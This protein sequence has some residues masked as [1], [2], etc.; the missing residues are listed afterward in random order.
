MPLRKSRAELDAELTREWRQLAG[1][2]ALLNQGIS[3]RLGINGT[4]LQCLS[5]L[6][7][8]GPIAAGQLAERTGL[9]TGAVTGVIDRLEKAGLVRRERDSVDRRKVIVQPLSDEELRTRAPELDAV[10]RSILA[11]AESEATYTDEQLDLIVRF[12]RRSHP[13]IQNQI[14]ALRRGTD[15]ATDPSAP[16]AGTTT[17]RLIFSAGVAHVTIDGEA[18]SD[19]LYRAHF[20]GPVPEIRVQDGTVAVRYRRF[21][22]FEGRPRG[23]RFSLSSVI[24]WDLEVQGG[25]ARFTADLHRLVVRSLTVKGGGSEVE[26][27]LPAPVGVVPLRISGGVSRLTVRRPAGTALSL[28]VNGGASRLV[29]DAQEFGGIGGPIRLQ[30]REYADNADHYAVEISGGASRLTIGTR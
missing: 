8:A 15:P 13:V 28:Q 1:E 25:V 10:F 20:D 9:T 24:P 5:V 29:L 17:G 30:S 27:D 7:T 26:I 12:I 11:G 19:D 16:R 18:P 6:G 3:D 4:D 23:S 2:L 22:L 21:S 14:A